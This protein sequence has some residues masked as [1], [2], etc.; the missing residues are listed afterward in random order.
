MLI[1]MFRGIP[2]THS[3]RIHNYHFSIVY[4]AVRLNDEGSISGQ[5]DEVR[6]LVRHPLKLSYC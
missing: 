6:V 3:Q 2:N 1:T 4:I 5:M